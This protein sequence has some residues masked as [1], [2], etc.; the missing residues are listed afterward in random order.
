MSSDPYDF[1]FGYAAQRGNFSDRVERRFD[2]ADRVE[3]RL[4]LCFD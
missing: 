2:R 3:N 4:L 1:P